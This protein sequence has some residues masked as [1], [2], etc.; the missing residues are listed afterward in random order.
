M[1]TGTEVTSFINIANVTKAY[2]FQ[3]T[4]NHITLGRNKIL[5]RFTDSQDVA[6]LNS[7]YRNIDYFDESRLGV[8]QNYARFEFSMN[9]IDSLSLID[10]R[11][12]F[13]LWA[14]LTEEKELGISTVILDNTF[15]QNDPTSPL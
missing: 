6:I 9:L 12:R 14:L 7:Q 2:L 15:N 10:D 5:H 13:L 1:M 11:S 4:Y 3:N 8:F